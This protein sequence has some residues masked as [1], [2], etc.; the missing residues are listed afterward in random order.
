MLSRGSWL[1]SETKKALGDCEKIGDTQL[2]E[3]VLWDP[4]GERSEAA[5][6]HCSRWG[7]RLGADKNQGVATSLLAIAC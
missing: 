5:S 1:E 2:C 3:E 4:W 6:S 7:A